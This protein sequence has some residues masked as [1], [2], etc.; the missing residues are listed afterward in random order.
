MT[1]LY[2]DEELK[3]DLLENDFNLEFSA[4]VFN[5]LYISL[6]DD[7]VS[8]ELLDY[9]EDEMLT[10]LFYNIGLIRINYD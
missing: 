10:D 1:R 8:A 7:K 2:F 3:I 6:V 5:S 4:V 9:L